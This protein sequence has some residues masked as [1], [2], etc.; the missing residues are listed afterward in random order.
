M[1]W[2]LVP[3]KGC[4]LEYAAK[5]SNYT[6]TRRSMWRVQF[7]PLPEFAVHKLIT[8]GVI[9]DAGGDGA[10]KDSHCPMKATGGG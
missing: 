9:E 2:L 7:F 10:V 3:N 8:T 6:T 4:R 5:D 1:N